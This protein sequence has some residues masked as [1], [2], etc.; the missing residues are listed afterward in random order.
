MRPSM[1][2][3]PALLLS[4]A[5]LAA[6]PTAAAPD[7]PAAGTVTLSFRGSL[8]DALQ[9]IAKQ[10][11]ISVVATGPL[12][13]PVEVHLTGVSGEQALRTLAR[14]YDLALDEEAGLW[15]LR[16]GDAE[17]GHGETG[18]GEHTGRPEHAEP[19]AKPA[20]PD[21]R[22]NGNPVVLP[23][24][25]NMPDLP[26]LPRLPATPR[27]PRMDDVDDPE[28]VVVHGRNYTVSQE[29]VV[30]DVVVYGGNLTVDGHVRKD[31]AV[32]GGNMVVNGTVEKDAVA[33]GGN[34]R[35]DGTVEGDAHAFGGNVELGEDALV[36]GDVSSFG[37]SVK[38]ADGAQV[39][40][41]RE[42]FAMASR[43]S[44]RGGTGAAE[45]LGNLII[46]FALLFALGFAFLMFAPARMKQLGEEMLTQPLACG[47]TGLLSAVALVPLI[48]L[49]VVTLI[50]IPVAIALLLLA[51]VGVLLGLPA[52]ASELGTR[53]PV[54]RGRKTQALVLALGTGV[55]MV[56]FSLPK[57]GTFFLVMTLFVSLGALVR[58]RFGNRPRGMPEPLR[59]AAAPY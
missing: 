17:T 32:V 12:D 51:P 48:V 33:M 55:L 44:E 42:T 39:H 5:L 8:R 54:L 58:T 49:L 16:A 38:Q 52:L 2:L 53:L 50:G 40:G 1:R 35:V 23:D 30:E 56:L 25:S 20:L 41:K 19:P 57:V 43:K 6:A 59:P 4:A 27:P 24:L 11:G 47:L 9:A 45:W 18:H 13:T 36:D 29:Q 3:L 21:L 31:A 34:L 37:G 26:K 14:A 22:I 10:S 46:Q 28:D 7:S 15:V